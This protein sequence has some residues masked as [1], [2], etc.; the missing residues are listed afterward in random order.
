MSQSQDYGFCPNCGAVSKNG[1]CTS[2]GYKKKG[3]FNKPSS[4]MSTSAS[5]TSYDSY[6]SQPAQSAPTETVFDYTKSGNASLSGTG[7][8]F[9]GRS[10]S[11]AKKG[12]LAYAITAISLIVFFIT[13]F[14][15]YHSLKFSGSDNDSVKKPTSSSALDLARG[16][17][18]S[19]SVSSTETSVPEDNDWDEDFANTFAGRVYYNLDMFD[20]PENT[21]Y[22]DESDYDYYQQ[23][24][25]YIYDDYI[26]TDLDYK[27]V[28]KTWKYNGYYAE[29]Y[30]EEYPDRAFIRCDYPVIE[31]DSL[32]FVDS[33]ND[34][35]VDLTTYMCDYYDLVE[36]YLEEGEVC[37]CEAYVYVT[38]MSEDVLSLLLQY[39]A[40]YYVEEDEEDEPELALSTVKSVNFDM[41][42]GEIME[43]PKLALDEDA[44]L[45][46]LVKDIDEQNEV[47]FL[48]MTTMDALK[49]SYEEGELLW[50]FN[51]LGVE[52]MYAFPD[53]Y[54]YFSCTED[55][56]EVF[57]K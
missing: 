35:I 54:G 11:S 33:V 42:T 13:G 10:N 56:D 14:L 51:P 29:E 32:S 24:D 21:K 1:V 37:Y 38:F 40:Y 6:S 55:P 23:Q 9:A 57:V 49:E 4:D 3:V 44:F 8:S 5:S 18:S 17:Y 52:F 22:A 53:Y 50:F 34:N 39:D 15:I 2:C 43:M 7:S 41:K 48:E 20:V 45:E 16:N 30:G 47:D 25:F 31:S 12:Y 28:N 46:R 36:D 27:I 19:V 26:R